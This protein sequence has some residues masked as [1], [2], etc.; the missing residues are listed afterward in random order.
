MVKNRIVEHVVVKAGS[1]VP[2]EL[3]P[4]THTDA[5]REA[6]T[7]LYRE[8]GFARSLLAY[9]LKDARLKLID[10]H[11]RQS[12]DPDQE[13]T[14][15]VLDVTDSEARALLLSI[16][17]L[18]QLAGYDGETLHQL[19]QITEQES[20]TVRSLWATLTEADAAAEKAVKSAR[21]A[22]EKAEDVLHEQ[23]LIVVECQDEPDQVKLLRQLKGM[24]LKVTAKVG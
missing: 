18:A 21:E 5:Q 6:I 15:E 13:V 11:L 16:D 1:L 17:P 22:Q 3:N 20:E 7:G 19:R 23:Y 2:H 24:G 14:V 4:R 12:L 10:G 8:I 9:R